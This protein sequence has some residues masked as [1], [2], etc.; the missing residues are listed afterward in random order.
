[1][2]GISRVCRGIFHPE[3]HHDG[4]M[5][6]QKMAGDGT[7]HLFSRLVCMGNGGPYILVQNTPLIQF[8][9]DLRGDKQGGL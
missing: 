4:A 8:R 6:G 7:L 9:L 3:G 5:A 2:N 1:M